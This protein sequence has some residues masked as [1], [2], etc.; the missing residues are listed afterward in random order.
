MDKNF[1]GT[2]EEFLQGSLFIVLA[3]CI[4]CD[5]QVISVRY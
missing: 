5:Y 1:T 2:M 4:Q 3:S